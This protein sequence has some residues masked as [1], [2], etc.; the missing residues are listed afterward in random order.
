MGNSS[1]TPNS[2]ASLRTVITPS[3][4]SLPYSSRPISSSSPRKQPPSA[5]SSVR[6]E[7]DGSTTDLLSSVDR[8]VL[9]SDTKSKKLKRRPGTAD[10]SFSTSTS[11]STIKASPTK[12]AQRPLPPL[13]PTLSEKTPSPPAIPEEWLPYRLPPYQEILSRIGSASVRRNQSLKEKKTNFILNS[14]D[15]GE[16]SSS[17]RS[18]FRSPSKNTPSDHPSQHYSR[19]QKNTFTPRL[20]KTNYQDDSPPNLIRKSQVLNGA[21]SNASFNLPEMQISK[22]LSNDDCFPRSVSSFDS[23]YFNSSLDEEIEPIGFKRAVPPPSPEEMG[24][25]NYSVASTPICRS[26]PVESY[27]ALQQRIA[28][29]ARDQS[30]SNRNDSIVSSDGSIDSNEGVEVH[31][32]SQQGDY[33]SP[34]T[35]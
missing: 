8:L 31:V 7:S 1:S 11:A 28:L 13:T 5:S 32:L 21:I 18:P 25:Q 19:Y 4:P 27:F 35:R 34:I 29:E 26:E 24:W 22:S 20:E 2:A 17:T 6:E 23:A 12:P 3:I 16:N 14:G 33:L 15:I 30:W 10:S 9:K